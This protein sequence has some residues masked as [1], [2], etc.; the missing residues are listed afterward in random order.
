MAIGIFFGF[1]LPVAQIPLSAATAVVLRAN[2]PAAMGSTLVTNP[3]TFAPIYYL[4][5]RTGAWLTGHEGAAPASFPAAEAVSAASGPH[6]APPPGLWQRIQALGKP[7]IVGLAVFAGL[8]AARAIQALAA[9][10]P[11]AAP[12]PGAGRSGGQPAGPLAEPA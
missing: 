3:I 6:G 1:L 8:V 11:L 7:L 4:A 5:W 2:V 12:G 9:P 10:A